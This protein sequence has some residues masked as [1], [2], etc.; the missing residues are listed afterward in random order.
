MPELSAA[1][2]QALFEHLDADAG[3]LEA[4][5]AAGGRFNTYVAAWKQARDATAAATEITPALCRRVLDLP[6]GER[7]GDPGASVRDYLVALLAALVAAEAD[8]KYGMTGSSDWLYDLYEPLQRYG[9]IPAWRDG[10]GVGYRTDGTDHPED[11]ALADR[12]L[13]AAIHSLTTPTVRTATDGR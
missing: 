12:I 8:S 3:P 6:V 11:A 9:L 1:E 13:T 4:H 2:E 10:Y 5:I 7:W